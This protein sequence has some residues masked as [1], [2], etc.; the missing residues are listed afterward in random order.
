MAAATVSER[1]LERELR[2]NPIHRIGFNLHRFNLHRD[3]II[4]VEK[5]IS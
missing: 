5:F 3:P 1:G 4:R 2:F